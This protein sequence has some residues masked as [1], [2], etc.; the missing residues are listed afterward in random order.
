MEV[1]KYTIG[2]K[3]SLHLNG[4]S[5]VII[6]TPALG[7]SLNTSETAKRCSY[8]RSTILVIQN[9]SL[10]LIFCALCQTSSALAAG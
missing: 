9:Y 4:L 8:V 6:K 3:T 1:V 10:D 5:H 7:S 2:I